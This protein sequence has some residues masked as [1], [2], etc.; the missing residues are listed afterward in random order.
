MALAIAPTIDSNHIE[1]ST[2]CYRLDRVFQEYW[3]RKISGPILY[4]RGDLYQVRIISSNSVR[5]SNIVTEIFSHRDCL[6]P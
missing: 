4:G 1:I 2:F 6:L 5:W 3:E